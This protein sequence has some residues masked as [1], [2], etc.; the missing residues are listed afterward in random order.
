[1]SSENQK[2]MPMKD[3]FEK[4]MKTFQAETGIAFANI[5]SLFNAQMQD[6]VM[7]FANMRTELESTKNKATALAAEKDQLIIEIEELKRLYKHPEKITPE[8]TSN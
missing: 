1:M 6:M 3:A 5:N 8:P 4:M 7:N 2:K